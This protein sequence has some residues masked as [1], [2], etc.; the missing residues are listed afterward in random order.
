M[1]RDFIYELWLGNYEQGV[2]TIL[3]KW[4][5]KD[6]IGKIKLNNRL[7][8]DVSLV[9]VSMLFKVLHPHLVATCGITFY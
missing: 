9:S 4:I 5:L 7:C 1:M 8:F 6:E 3:K 2:K